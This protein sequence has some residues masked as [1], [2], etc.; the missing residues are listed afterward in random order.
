MDSRK[1]WSFDES[2]AML[3]PQPNP[4]TLLPIAAPAAAKMGVVSRAL[5]LMVW[6]GALGLG[7]LWSYWPTLQMMSDRWTHNPQYSHGFLV[8][9]FA[10]VVLWHRRNLAPGLLAPTWWGLPLL[11]GGRDGVAATPGGTRPGGSR[12]GQ[13]RENRDENP[14]AAYDLHE[15]VP[16]RPTILPSR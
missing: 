5:A 12:S 6:F 16:P 11:V 10:A 14:V 2:G 1:R 15:P 13:G 8:P 3:R 4:M 9:V 7:L